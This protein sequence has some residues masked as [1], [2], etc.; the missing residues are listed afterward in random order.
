MSKNIKIIIERTGDGVSALSETLIIAKAIQDAVYV[1]FKEGFQIL[2]SPTS[3]IVDLIK[4]M[5]LE[6]QVLA[7]KEQYA[8]KG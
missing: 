5:L 4:I 3:E 7:I 2:V 1:E 8:N 6:L